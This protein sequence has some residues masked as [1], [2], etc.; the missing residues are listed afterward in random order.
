MFNKKEFDEEIHKK[1]LAHEDINNLKGLEVDVVYNWKP[2]D[3][4]IFDRT[5][6]HCSSSNL[7]E[8]KIGFTTAT[9][10]N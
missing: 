8:K 7:P 5:R 9:S 4:L 6:L 10:K 3:L 1:Y 2:G